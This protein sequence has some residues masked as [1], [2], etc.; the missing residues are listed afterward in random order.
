MKKWGNIRVKFSLERPKD[1]NI[2]GNIKATI[3]G[4][5]APLLV[6]DNQDTEVDTLI[7]SFN[8]AMTET[9]NHIIGKQRPT[10]KPWVTDDILNLCD[11]RRELKQKKNTDKGAQLHREANQQVKKKKKRPQL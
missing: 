9:S 6:L 5:F 4:K 11:K 2:A 1:P 8:T 10:K 3:E 7:H